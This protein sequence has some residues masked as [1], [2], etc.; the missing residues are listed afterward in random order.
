MTKTDAELKIA[1]LNRS[2]ELLEEQVFEERVTVSRTFV[3]LLGIQWIAVLIATVYW[4]PR[5]WAGVS[6][7]IHPHVWMALILGGLFTGLPLFLARTD[8]GSLLTRHM[9][10]IGQ[11]LMGSL[12][13]HT[14]G[15][16]IENHFHVFG[17]LAF[18]ALYRDARVIATATFVVVFDHF[19]RGMWFPQSIYGVVIPQLWRS[20]EHGLWV[21]IE[22]VV[23]LVSCQQS[24]AQLRQLGIRRAELELT[25]DV[26]AAQVREGTSQLRQSQKAL[27]ASEKDYRNLF[28]DSP[29]GMY[30]CASDGRVL[31]A[32]SRLL[33]MTGYD[34]IDDLRTEGFRPPEIEQFTTNLRNASSHAELVEFKGLWRRKD[35]TELRV[36]GTARASLDTAGQ[37]RYIDVT[38]EDITARSR[39]E[40]L[41][42]DRAVV[43]ERI[44]Q[45]RPLS[46][47]LDQ[48]QTLLEN[49]VAGSRCSISIGPELSSAS[50]AWV[51]S[52]GCG[53]GAPIGNLAWYALHPRPPEVLESRAIQEAARLAVMALDHDGL[54]RKLTH[55]ASYD[56]VTDL[57]NR[58]YFESLLD[59]TIAEAKTKQESFAVLWI[60]LDRF[61]QINDTLGYRAGDL[62][63]G[64]IARKVQDTLQPED[65][66]ARMSSDEFAVV[67]RNAT[68]QASPRQA[69]DRIQDVFAKTLF[70]EPH[71]VSIS[72][73]LGIAVFPWDG[74]TARELLT[75]AD[76]A[77]C[78]AKK[79]GGN[80][81]VLFAPEMGAGMAR[82]KSIEIH[83]TTALR[84][85]EFEL[86]FQP[87]VSL[88]ATDCRVIAGVEALL[89]W[90]NPVLGSVSPA[91]FIPVAEETGTILAIGDWVLAQA[92]RQSVAWAAAGLR[93]RM[94]V[95][96]SALQFARP[97]FVPK[98]EATLAATGV[99]PALLEVELTET[100]LMQNLA[101]TD[102]KVRR[103]RA[104]GISV[105]IDDFGTGYC[106]LS[107]LHGLSANTLKVDQS[108]VRGISPES[109]GPAA[110][111]QA[112]VE[113]ARCL[114][115]TVIAEGVETEYQFSVLE[116]TGCDMVQGYLLSK[117]LPAAAMEK[118]LAANESSRAIYRLSRSLGKSTVASE[119]ADWLERAGI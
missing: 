77:M 82:R 118:L 103:L 95:N 119:A 19:F 97:D 4:T 102:S 46:E 76:I 63:L 113:M 60:E 48:I 75:H 79:E 88:P 85:Q 33:A 27:T 98:L 61:K 93:I 84:N 62:L 35:T 44:G 80:R 25:N 101:D 72:A 87:Q 92:C 37:P 106:S 9:V 68:S 34:S 94:G 2:N 100:S 16:R 83:M 8:P 10:A 109:Q 78:R 53:A 52:L 29:V 114:N 54:Y 56:A 74:E 30:R 13:I 57:P 96:V 99:D 69:A 1:I 38:V 108:F 104:L 39:A 50:D 58:I 55:Q 111:L 107:Y 73:S 6:S 24:L 70:L 67:V 20:L 22:D 28:A 115:L 3:W 105:A 47:I 51:I 5:T 12:L 45:N 21:V 7:S 40:D 71:H 14:S 112:I 117:P 42:R 23:L 91:E 116:K 49:Q 65:I 15:G 90:T 89:R 81:T 66:I 43:L 86:Y 59:Q 110:I 26:I 11:M 18:L 41:E 64:E 31:L 32:N 17:S 36:S